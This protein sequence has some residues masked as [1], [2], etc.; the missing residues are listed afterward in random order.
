MD[1][2]V[3]T[4]VLLSLACVCCVEDP[5]TW[6]LYRG[7]KTEGS[8]QVHVATFNTQDDRSCGGVVSCAE[9]NQ[10]NCESLAASFTDGQ[11]IWWC[12][13]ATQRSKP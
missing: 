12:E 11:E 13:S 1:E 8:G 5:D 10:G 3:V 6:Y 4:M 9:F 2:A 7:M